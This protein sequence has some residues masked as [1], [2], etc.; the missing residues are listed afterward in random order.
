MASIVL[1]QVR[2]RRVTARRDI[3]LEDFIVSLHALADAAASWASFYANHALVRTVVSFVHIGALV[4]GGGCAIAADRA[5]LSAPREPGARH[6]ADV[7]ALS[8]THR[9]VLLGLALIAASGFLLLAADIDAMVHSTTFWIKMGLVVLLIGNGVF[10]LRAEQ[11]ALLD[12]SAN[13]WQRVRLA[14]VLSLTL[15]FLTTLAG[16]AL[17]NVA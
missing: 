10:L 8:V 14:A 11:R 6:D 13:A 5:V 12:T 9:V 7:V 3:V 1:P 2:A 15:W 17:P 4:G 16:A